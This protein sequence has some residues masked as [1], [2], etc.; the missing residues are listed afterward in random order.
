M[1]KTIRVLSIDGGG[2]RGLFPA[3]M[4]HELEQASGRSVTDIF[5]VIVGSATGGIITVAISAGMKMEDIMDIYLNKATYILPSSFWRKLWNPFNLFAPRYPSANL[6]RLLEEKVGAAKTLADVKQRFGTD[7]I[8]LYGT[9]DMSPDLQPGE[10]PAFKVVIYNSAM[11]TYQQ[12]KLVDIAM[13]TSAAAVNL[14]LYQRYSESG[15]YAND[16]SLIGLTFCMNRQ[17]GKQQGVSLLENNALGLGAGPDD[18]KF[19]SLGCGSDGKSYVPRDEIGKGNWGMIKWMG[20]LISLVIETNMV[21]GR[22]C[23]EQLLDEDHYLRLTPYYKA[24]D[25]P[26][27]LKDKKLN[28]DVRD[29]AQLQAIRD[30][31]VDSFARDKDRLFQF[32]EL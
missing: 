11:A 2:T 4:L 16:P 13:R 22:Y 20:K 24:A 10:T 15:S 23:M 3:T 14:P 1:K 9:L 31:A 26:G 25:A 17:R 6:K 19:L 27:V 18:I 8:F 12:E 32:L 5:D 28:I 30:Y 7:T 21:A 29:A